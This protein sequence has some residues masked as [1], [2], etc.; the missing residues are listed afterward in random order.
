MLSFLKA[1]S[2]K[3]KP[4]LLGTPATPITLLSIVCQLET[5]ALV[6]QL[7]LHDLFISF[8]DFIIDTPPRDYAPL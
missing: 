8:F 1:S 5:F 2:L 7:A 4:K 6:S 3:A